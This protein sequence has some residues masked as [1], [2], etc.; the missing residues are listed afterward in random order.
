MTTTYRMAIE[1]QAWRVASDG[2][3]P[4]EAREVIMHRSQAGQ[5]PDG[6]WSWYTGWDYETA[7]TGDWVVQSEYGLEAMTDSYF[8]ECCTEVNP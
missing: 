2:S 3:L 7:R 4:E 6:G 8:R 5:E 1:V